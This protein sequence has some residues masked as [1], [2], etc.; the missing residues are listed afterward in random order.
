MKEAVL[1][2]KKE[3]GKVKCRL[4]NHRCL[5]LPG[6][7]GIC[8]VRENQDGTLYSLNYGKLI[9]RH[10]DPIEKKPLFHFHPGSRSYSI[11][12]VG[13]NFRCDFCQ[14]Y[15][16]SQMPKD[17]GLVMGDPVAPEEVVS[18]ARRTECLSISYTYTEPTI[19]FEYAY[20]TAKL[21]HAQEIKN[22]FV[23]NGFMGQES[24][25]M[26]RPYLQAA[27]IDLKAFTEKF[28]KETCGAR[29]APVL[30]NLKSMKKMGIWVE[31]TTLVI[32]TLNDSD[33][34]LRDIATFIATE[35]GPDT[36]WHVSRFHP[37]YKLNGIHATPVE[38]LLRAQEIGKAAGLYYVYTGNIPG[39]GGE[40]TFCHHCGGLLIER[41]GF[42]V[43]QY[44]VKNGQCHT[45]RADV[46]GVG[47]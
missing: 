3:E 10:V 27:N 6:K 17:Q 35:M 30:E 13:C 4:C 47:L 33:K 21:A 20:E 1:Y 22:V 38:T 11:A 40:N 43:L 37:M 41:L 32:P 19:F 25:E 16:I 9:A 7:R 26:I 39:Q 31:V 28:Y 2:G 8:G 14:N 18:A 29:L 42:S 5:I 23:S 44:N 15:E 46:H 34:E 24:L 36:P 12:A 45:C